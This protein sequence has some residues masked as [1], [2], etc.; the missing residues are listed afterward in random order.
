MA[1]GNGSSGRAETRLNIS[2]PNELIYLLMLCQ[3]RT[4]SVSMNETIRRLLESHPAL[5]MI[6]MEH[7]TEGNDT[8]PRS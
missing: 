7:Y 1:G 6:A 3:K 8:S 5:T 4:R 2:L